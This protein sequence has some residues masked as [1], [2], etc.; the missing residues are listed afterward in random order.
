MPLTHTADGIVS[1]STYDFPDVQERGLMSEHS[2]TTQPVVCDS[3]QS[4]SPASEATPKKQRVAWVDIAKGIAIILVITGHTIERN[5]A[6]LPP[7]YMFHMPLFFIMAGY[8][9]KPKP[10]KD[11]FI[12]SAKRLLIPYV[13][14]FIILHG[15]NWF[16]SADAFTLHSLKDMVLKFI[17]AS[18]TANEDMGIPSVATA[19]FLMCLFVSRIILN[20]LEN[21]FD[22]HG[23]HLGIRAV[24]YL[25][26]AVCGIVIGYH[27]HIYLPFCLDLAFVCSGF[28]W[29]GHIARTTG[30]MEK[31][32]RTWWAALI[33]LIVLVIAYQYSYLELAARNFGIVPLCILG[34]FGGSLFACW[35]SMQI[36]RYST[37]LTRFFSWTGRNSML[38]YCFHCMDWV[39]AWRDIP[40]IQG[41][42][43]EHGIATFVRTLRDILLTLLVKQVTEK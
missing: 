39:V 32:G 16:A 8:T 26:L 20:S 7:I 1:L 33:G 28:M 9:F 18:G 37:L 30:F 14:I 29:V 36:E 34:A 25:I 4:T 3:S 13:L 24:S 6:L 19:W 5:S 22:A 15:V 42:P 23:A 21:F 41:L 2:S 43:F 10:F 11:C 27:F 17:W 40:A 35:V 31:W 12:T 38:I